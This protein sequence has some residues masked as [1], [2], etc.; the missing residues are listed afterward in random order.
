MSTSCRIAIDNGD[1]T[2][3]SIYCHNDGYPSGVG[4]ILAKYYTPRN[5]SSDEALRIRNKLKELMANG[6]LSYLG[7]ETTG[8]MNNNGSLSYKEWRDEDAP[9]RTESYPDFR[10]GMFD[11]EAE[12]VYLYRKVYPARAKYGWEHEWVV[13]SYYPEPLNKAIEEDE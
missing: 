1:E 3:T 11:G 10:R 2:I 13:Y 8:G 7:A 6:D 4:A 12:Y 5:D 9:A